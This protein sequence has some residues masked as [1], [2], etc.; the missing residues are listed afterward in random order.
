[1]GGCRHEATRVHMCACV[2]MCACV[3]VCARMC[4]RVH[5]RVINGLKYP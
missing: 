3:R 4:T 5:V 2:C 1:M